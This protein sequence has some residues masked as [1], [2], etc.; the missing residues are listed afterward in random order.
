[1]RLARVVEKKLRKTFL[2]CVWKRIAVLHLSE[3][4]VKPVPIPE[5][6][7]KKTAFEEQKEA[8]IEI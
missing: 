3:G 6:T 2:V 7:R 8:T 5:S 1:M 4:E